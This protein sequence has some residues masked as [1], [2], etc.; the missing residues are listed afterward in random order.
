MKKNEKKMKIIKMKFVQR[1]QKQ[2]DEPK[3]LTIYVDNIPIGSVTL[4][5]E[6]TIEDIKAFI[7]KYRGKGQKRDLDLF[8]NRETKLNNLDDEMELE[9]IW[10]K[11]KQPSIFL[12]FK[13]YPV[14]PILGY[15][16]PL[17]EERFEFD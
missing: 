11:L 4:S 17:Y 1:L 14:K 9:K 12:N 7:E 8:I 13:S 6:N 16:K 15:P 10:D 5:K 3:E 2:T